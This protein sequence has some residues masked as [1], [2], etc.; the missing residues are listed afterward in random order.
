MTT[1]ALPSERI[2][3]N[4]SASSRYDVRHAAMMV[5]ARLRREQV[6]RDPGEHRASA[7]RH[8]ARRR[9]RVQ[10][11]A[12]HAHRRLGRTGAV[13]RDERPTYADAD[14]RQP[15][16]YESPAAPAPFTRVL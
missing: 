14:K 8:V 9:R 4:G 6:D 7:E 13:E 1:S 10:I 12:R 16:G 3:R 11:V 5:R 2:A 15:R